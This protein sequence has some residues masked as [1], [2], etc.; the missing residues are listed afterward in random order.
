MEASPHGL[1]ECWFWAYVVRAI[2][3]KESIW[4]QHLR[5]RGE[6]M[7][8]LEERVDAEA[9]VQLCAQSREGLIREE[10]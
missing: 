10:D 4:A 9:L 8:D 6:G 7:A 5:A 3:R 2:Q 1:G